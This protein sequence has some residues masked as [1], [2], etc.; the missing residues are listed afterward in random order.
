MDYGFFFL[1]L[2]FKAH[3]LDLTLFKGTSFGTHAGVEEL[4]FE[5]RRLLAM[6]MIIYNIYWLAIQ[7]CFLPSKFVHQ[8]PPSFNIIA[9]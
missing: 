3:H 8:V 6:G 4:L 7:R 9:S 1:G 5:L 2:G